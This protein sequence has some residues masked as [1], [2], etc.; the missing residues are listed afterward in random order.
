MSAYYAYVEGCVE[1]KLKFLKYLA[2]DQFCDDLDY[3]VGT[4]FIYKY[5]PISDH[6]NIVP[7]Y[8]RL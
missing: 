4:I 7:R 5:I 3:K 1:L 6:C 2:S 8:A